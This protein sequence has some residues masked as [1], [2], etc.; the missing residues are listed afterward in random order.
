M[1]AKVKSS[2]VIGV[3]G[4]PIEV[5]VDI[6]LGLPM[7]ATVGL[8][9]GA[10]RESK[11]RVKAAINNSGYDFP[12]HKITVNLAP[13]DV[14]K[15]GSGYDLP[16][17]LGILVASG[18]IRDSNHSKYCIVGELSLDGSVRPVSGILPMTLAARDQGLKGIIVPAANRAEA[19][20]VDG[21][22]VI[23]VEFL[24]QT[25][26][27]VAGLKTIPPFIVDC[28]ALF[29]DSRVFDVDFEDVKGQEHVK[30]ALEIAASGGH[31]I[32]MKGPP[33]SG[34]TM[35][36]RRLPTILPDLTFEEALETTKYTASLV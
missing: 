5:E 7:F 4:I 11:D 28:H 13:A 30:R 20:I 26:E 10:V 27:F 34:K 3:N 36:A 1:L 29:F 33:G 31:N 19:A 22:D 24:H 21:I 23:P 9:D 15:S 6:A 12:H 8:P 16:M 18:L 32:L 25:V 17:A 14:K 2:T 35:L